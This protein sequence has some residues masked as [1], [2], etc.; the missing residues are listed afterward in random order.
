MITLTAKRL[1]RNRNVPCVRLERS[2]RAVRLS[3]ASGTNRAA[4]LG[5]DV[6]ARKLRYSACNENFM[7]RLIGSGVPPTIAARVTDAGEQ[8]ISR[9]FATSP[10]RTRPP[11]AVHSRASATLR[12]TAAASLFMCLLLAVPP[13]LAASSSRLAFQVRE[14]RILNYFLREGPVASH[15]VLRSG[16]QP[17][18]L[19]AFPAG[20]SGV[21]LW[22]ARQ[23]RSAAW[24]I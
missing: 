23:A 6:R 21:G 5:V 19:I 18:I 3:E 10:L 17:R 11:M 13:A 20:N 14:G 15:L 2:L 12:A 24:Q 9:R 8:A 22:F 16:P 4:I 1:L 7:E